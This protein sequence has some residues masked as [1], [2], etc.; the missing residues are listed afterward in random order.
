MK[1]KNYQ[2]LYERL[3]RENLQLKLKIK[4]LI[5]ENESLFRNVV[6]LKVESP[7][8]ANKIRNLE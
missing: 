4:S 2:L 1:P 3:K 8:I 6:K 7:H 5:K